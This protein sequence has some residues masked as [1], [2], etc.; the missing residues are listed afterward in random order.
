MNHRD[1]E[2]RAAY[3]RSVFADKSLEE[4]YSEDR[5]Q[6]WDGFSHED[7]KKI[8]ESIVFVSFA[9]ISGAVKSPFS[10]VN[11]DPPLP[12]IRAEID[13]HPY[14]FELGEI[15][16]EGLARAVSYSEKTGEITGGPFS[17]LHPLLKMFRDRCAK[18][19]PTRGDQVDLLLHYTKQYPAE[20]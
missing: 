5:R 14:Y 9:I 18:S 11:E 19:Y 10:Y 17:Q 3:T 7:Q 8:K 6:Q 2:K 15:T 20:D 1:A 12:D 13:G 16:D 4:I